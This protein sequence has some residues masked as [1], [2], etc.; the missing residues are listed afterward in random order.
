MK[1]SVLLHLV[2]AAVFLICACGD[3]TLAGYKPKNRNEADIIA[4]LKTYKSAI[5]SDDKIRF[6]SCFHNDCTFMI[7][8][9]GSI[10]KAGLSKILPEWLRKWDTVDISDIHIDLKENSATV[11]V[12]EKIH[13]HGHETLGLNKKGLTYF[14]LVREKDQWLIV[15]LSS[16]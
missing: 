5:D 6:L 7:S 16:E 2:C 11:K 10:D 12:K 8:T 15:K 3:N 13:F 9:G 4:L 14:N 1:D